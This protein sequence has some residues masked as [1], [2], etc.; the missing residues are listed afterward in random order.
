[1]EKQYGRYGAVSLLLLVTTVGLTS[2]CASKKYVRAQVNTSANELSARMEEKDRALQNGVDSNSSQITELSGVSREHTQ[3][4]GALDNGLKATDEKA[5]QAM[6]IG[7]EAQS[8]ASEAAGHVSQ[9][10]TA[11]QNRN[12]YTPV[13]EYSIPFAFGSAAVNKK[14]ISTLEQIAQQVKDSPNAILVLEGR[15]DSTGDAAYNIQLGEKRMNAVVRY[16]VVDQAVPMQQIYK[17][18]FGEARPVASN[19]TAEGRAQN[20][21]VVVRIMEPNLGEGHN[22]AV[23]S[24]ATPASH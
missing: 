20:R 7:Q 12:H 16:L 14:S 13:N 2:G 15:T 21:V 4:I 10:D 19:K 3:K 8:T 18:S 9:L 23:V 22:G 1:M 11:F 17:M 5:A 24:Q 6:N